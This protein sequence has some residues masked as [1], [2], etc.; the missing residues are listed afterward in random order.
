MTHTT[1]I[2]QPVRV[3]VTGGAGFIGSNFLLHMVPRFPD[4]QFVNLDALTYAGNLF[5]LVKIHDAPNYTFVKGSITDK[6]LVADLFE[7]FDFTSIVHFA[8]ESHVDRSIR[9]PLAFVE[10]NITGTVNLLE[11]ARDAWGTDHLS[12]RRFVHVSTDEVFGSL[13]KGGVFKLD[14]PYAPRSPYSASKAAADH[15]VRAYANTYGLPAIISNC[16]NN[17]GPFQFPEKLIPLSILRSLNCEPVPVYGT[18]DN[19]RDWLHVQDHCAALELILFKG[20]DSETY[21]VGGECEVTNLDLVQLLLNLVD[22]ALGQ[23]A[24]SSQELITF[25]PDRPGHDFRYAV[26]TGHIRRTLGW[27]PS[28]SLEEGLRGTIAWYLSNRDWLDAINDQSYRTYLTEQY[29]L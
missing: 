9:T 14:T 1:S 27:Q 4:V 29:N 24:G 17:Y 7:R 28:Y 23:P 20:H 11:A 25:V 22:E 10:T 13:G 2:H 3:L 19:I 21:L 16:S 6:S 5:N 15:F 12:Q 26:D 18:G 8:A